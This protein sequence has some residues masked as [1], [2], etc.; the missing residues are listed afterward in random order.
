MIKQKSQQF[1]CLNCIELC[2]AQSCYDC[3]NF[4]TNTHVYNKFF[5]NG[6][7]LSEDKVVSFAR[8]EYGSLV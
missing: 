2:F 4:L 7:A 3:F 6:N 8:N 5:L 1:L